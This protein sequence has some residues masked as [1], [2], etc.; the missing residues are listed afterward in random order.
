MPD[1]DDSTARKGDT[2][3]LQTIACD[4]QGIVD[5]QGFKAHSGSRVGI[6]HIGAE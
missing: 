5:T 6:G 4:S 2:H 1:T 3:R